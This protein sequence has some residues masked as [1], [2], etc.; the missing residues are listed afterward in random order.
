MAPLRKRLLIISQSYL[1]RSSRGFDAYYGKDGLDY[2]WGRISI[3][4]NDFC[5]KPY[6]YTKKAS[7]NDFSIEHDR[8]WVLPML[9]K[10]LANKKLQLIASPWSPPSCLKISHGGRLNPL[11]YGRYAKYIHKWL[12][13]YADEGI[14][15]NYI[16]PR[17]NLMLF[18][19]GSRAFILAA[20]KRGLRTNI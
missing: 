11:Y 7:L 19:L 8:K 12:R 3:G 9:Q 6:E 2:R 16:T 5:L 20:R 4:S 18:S 10:I 13:A 15:I 14:R 1:P 17:T